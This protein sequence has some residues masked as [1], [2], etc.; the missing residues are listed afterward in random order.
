M[1]E[2]CLLPCSIVLPQPAFWYT[3]AYLPSA[4]PSTEGLVLPYQ[5]PV[6]MPID[7]ST[8]CPHKENSYIEASFFQVCQVDN[9]G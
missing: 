4:A 3:K 9:R 7:M 6:I 5:P 2:C 1:E 8:G